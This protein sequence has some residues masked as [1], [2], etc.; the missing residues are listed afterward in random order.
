LKLRGTTAG[1]SQQLNGASGGE[2]S[3]AKVDDILI[4]MAFSEYLALKGELSA[5]KHDMDRQLTIN[6]SLATEL[7][8]YKSA[9]NCVCRYFLP[10]GPADIDEILKG[11]RSISVEAEFPAT[12]DDES[13]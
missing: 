1:I 9:L 5:L 2:V 13:V 12:N 4:S 10:A 6:T 11:K 7:E 8:R 3:E